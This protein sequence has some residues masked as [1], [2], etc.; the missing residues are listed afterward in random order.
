MSLLKGSGDTPIGVDLDGRCI[1]A[2][3]MNPSARKAEVQA[4]TFVPRSNPGE[5]IDEK[6]IERLVRLLPKRGFIGNE[7]VLA[8]PADRLLTGIL[9]LPPRRTGAPVDR[10]ARS[11]LSRMH[12]V[13]AATLEMASW[14]L[15]VPERA[16]DTEPVMVAA[17]PYSGSNGLLDAFE[18][19]DYSVQALDIR[20]WALAR[21]CENML[22]DAPSMTA[23]LEIGWLRTELV[24]LHGP[25]VVYHRQLDDAG[26]EPLGKKLAGKPLFDAEAIQLIV[27]DVRLGDQVAGDDSE[28]G[29][30]FYG[31]AAWHFDGIAGELEVPL[32]YLQNQYPEGY[33]TKLL[34]TGP[35]ALIDGADAHLAA[36]LDIE[37]QVVSPSQLAAC[38][39][40]LAGECGPGATVAMGLAQY[41]EG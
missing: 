27:N 10:I 17:C 33:V 14:A 34:L 39:S 23:I 36:K 26:L 40:E 5:R 9:E 20:A 19:L 1:R 4:A 38:P 37:V 24:G 25:T 13:S 21:A 7:V 29:G 12:K 22:A 35:G 16:A 31:K 41:T 32:S 30:E 3:Q 28:R 11:E 2:V 6:E 18:S 15:P 8:V